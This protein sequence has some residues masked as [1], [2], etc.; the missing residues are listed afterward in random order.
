MIDE[1]HLGQQVDLPVLIDDFTEKSLLF[2][3]Q[4]AGLHLL[5]HPGNALLNHRV[6]QRGGPLHVKGASVVVVLNED[7]G[8]DGC[9]T[10][11][12]QA[13][14]RAGDITS[15]QRSMAAQR[16]ISTHMIQL[17]GVVTGS[18]NKRLQKLAPIEGGSSR[19][20]R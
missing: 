3:G 19:S 12:R 11:E 16:E 8:A 13:V 20:G 1:Q 17:I 6:L 2:I 14:S 7:I 5:L 15:F 9:S 18:L 10:V 4:I